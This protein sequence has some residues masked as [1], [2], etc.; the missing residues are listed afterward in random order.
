LKLFFL[1]GFKAKP[2]PKLACADAWGSDSEVHSIAMSLR[3]SAS[4]NHRGESAKATKT[5]SY[6]SA[7]V[8]AKKKKD[9]F[10]YM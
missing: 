4:R 9:H 2:E 1:T 5:T 10:M 3:A 6:C 7:F 8:L